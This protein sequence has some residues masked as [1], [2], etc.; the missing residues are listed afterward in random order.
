MIIVV[1]PAGNW[2]DSQTKFT[3]VYSATLPG[4]GMHILDSL[5]YSLDGDSLVVEE[6]DAPMVIGSDGGPVDLHMTRQDCRYTR[7]P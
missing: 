1:W 3:N 6:R 2:N 4:L 7:Q 5:T